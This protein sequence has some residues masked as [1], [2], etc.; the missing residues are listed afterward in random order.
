MP[1]DRDWLRTALDRLAAEQARSA[2]THLLRIE[3]PAF[4]GIPIY[5]KDESTHPTGSLKHRLARSLFLYGLCDGRIRRGQLVLDASSGSTA[6][7]EAYFARLLELPYV[8]VM[9][10][11]TSPRKIAEIEA[12]G[13]QCEFVDAADQVYARAEALAAKLGGHYLDQ[14]GMSERA[15]DWRGNN[16]IAESIL[17]QMQREPEPEP[18][19]I[20]CGA[21]TGGTSATIG[22]YLRYRGTATRLCVA[23]PEGAAFVEGWRSRDKAVAARCSRIEGIGRPR[24]EPSFRFDVVDRVEAIGDADSCAA[25]WLLEKITGR[26]FGGS[27]GTNLVGVLRLAREMREAGESGAIVTLLCDRGERYS[28]TVFNADWLAAQGFDIAPGMRRLAEALGLSVTD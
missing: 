12:L 3:F 21:G 6:I 19:W 1:A 24:I 7:S 18:R 15:T 16:N 11:D 22:R 28:E 20:V 27:S 10:H 13:G 17:A 5:F 14:F 4:P 23:D 26:R 9:T 8:A 2:D 25:A